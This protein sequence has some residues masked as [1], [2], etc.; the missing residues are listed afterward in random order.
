MLF[1]QSEL[2][3][4]QGVEVVIQRWRE[5]MNMFEKHPGE[6]GMLAAAE[7]AGGDHIKL[8][9]EAGRL[10][11]AIVAHRQ[12]VRLCEAEAT[13]A[14]D[15]ERWA[16]SASR[17]YD[18]VTLHLQAGEV[19]TA[20]QLIPELHDWADRYPGNEEIA[21]HDASATYNLVTTLGQNGD[22]EA[23]S[24]A[25]ARL[26]ALLRRHASVEELRR[27]ALG[28]ARNLAIFAA[29]A[30]RWLDVITVVRG[31]RAAADDAPNPVTGEMLRYI[32]AGACSPCLAA[33]QLDLAAEAVD[34]GLGVLDGRT[35]VPDTD[36]EREAFWQSLLDL[37]YP[38]A[39]IANGLAESGRLEHAQRLVRA[40]IDLQPRWRALDAERRVVLCAY[41][42]NAVFAVADS[43]LTA[44][45]PTREVFGW[46]KHAVQE[47]RA[48]DVETLTTSLVILAVNLVHQ[49]RADDDRPLA[50]QVL[51][52]AH[53]ELHGEHVREGLRSAVGDGA[54]AALDAAIAD[55]EAGTR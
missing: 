48:A 35:S 32:A 19:A 40:A 24:S 12:L 8:L 55:L 2:A 52:L 36:N 38:L 9:G 20:Q 31:L 21:N 17:G 51:A 28:A 53:D 4:Q 1:R 3:E 23:A 54:V 14:T 49:A 44:S 34:A 22:F 50:V 26:F 30:Q 45:V 18:L 10:T 16:M 5:L 27:S 25:Q 37:H 6:A 7:L 13:S 42:G 29:R 39:E 43:M 33:G 41:I 11:D 15:A 46:F 47:A